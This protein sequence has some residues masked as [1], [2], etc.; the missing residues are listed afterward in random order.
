VPLAL[1]P[2]QQSG[3]LWE[4]GNVASERGIVDLVNQDA[5]E[6]GSL[7]TRVGLKSRIDLND[8]CGGDGRKQTGL[9]R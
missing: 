7:V 8:E 5:E 4:G 1:V 9:I 3:P 2:A 6:G